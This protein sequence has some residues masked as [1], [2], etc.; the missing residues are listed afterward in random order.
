MRGSSRVDNLV[1]KYGDVSRSR[2]DLRSPS[3][4]PPRSTSPAET[5]T[6][7]ADTK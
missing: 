7:P 6:D 5:S 1:Q 4:P 2:E 3:T